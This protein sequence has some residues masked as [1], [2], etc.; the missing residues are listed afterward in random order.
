MY[1]CQSVPPFSYLHFSFPFLS[2]VMEENGPE[3]KLSEEEAGLTVTASEKEVKE[4]CN[5]VY[6]EDLVGHRGE[7]LK[8]CCGMVDM[9][10]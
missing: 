7:R 8:G 9:I 4:R 5:G 10:V 6:A 3:D 1:V 2:V